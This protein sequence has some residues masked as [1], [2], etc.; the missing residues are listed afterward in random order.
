[1]ISIL[2]GSGLSLEY[3]SFLE[4]IGSPGQPPEASQELT[5]Q[6]APLTA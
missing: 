1:M 6:I 4:A 3:T 2:Q 5:L